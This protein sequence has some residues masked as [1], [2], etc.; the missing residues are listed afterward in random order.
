MK[1]KN[2]YSL[3]VSSEEKGR[4]I[5]ETAIYGLVVASMTFSVFAFAS[6]SFNVPHTQKTTGSPAIQTIATQPIDSSVVAARG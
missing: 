4:S 1:T 5:F 6:Q 3:L 2:T